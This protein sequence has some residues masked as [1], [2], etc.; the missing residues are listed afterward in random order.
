LAI[1]SSPNKN[2]KRLWVPHRPPCEFLRVSLIYKLLFS[3]SW[4]GLQ[5][6]L[7]CFLDDDLYAGKFS[8]EL[9]KRR[10]IG[11]PKSAREAKASDKQLDDHIRELSIGM[12]DRCTEFRTTP[13]IYNS[14]CCCCCYCGSHAGAG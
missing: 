1:F 3:S 12:Q 4:N 10:I 14:V 5:I 11:K 6:W 8:I 7:I 9:Q 13:L 2:A